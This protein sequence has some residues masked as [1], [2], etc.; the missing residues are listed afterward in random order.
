LQKL[1][2]PAI[3][4]P[5]GFY[6]ECIKAEAQFSLGFMKTSPGFPF[7]NPGSFGAPGAGGSLGFADPQAQIGY[8]Y[9][10]NRMGVTLS[11]DPRDVALR[12]AL[13]SATPL[14]LHH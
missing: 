12:G 6:D 14:K 5:H 3:P 11:G 13:Y 7:G 2:A 1:T 4:A 10:T 9:V 8:G